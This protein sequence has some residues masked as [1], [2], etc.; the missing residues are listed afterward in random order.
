MLKSVDTDTRREALRESASTERRVS[1]KK[2]MLTLSKEV[3]RPA[4]HSVLQCWR[5]GSAE[6]R[7]AV[8]PLRVGS[9]VAARLRADVKE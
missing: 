5:N 2:R 8:F 4:W 3:V 9:A 6:I 1:T 7:M